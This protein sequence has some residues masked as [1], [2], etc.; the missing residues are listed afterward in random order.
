GQGQAFGSRPQAPSRRPRAGQ[1]VL[2]QPQPEL[3]VRQRGGHARPPLRV[4]R[5]AGA[6]GRLPPAVDPADQRR[7]PSARHELQPL[8]LRAAGGGGGGRPQG[9]GRPGRHRP[10]GLRRPGQAGTGEPPGIV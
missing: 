2:R 7:L 9:A 8:H 1:G 5:P 10:H 4:P 3:Q 6:Q